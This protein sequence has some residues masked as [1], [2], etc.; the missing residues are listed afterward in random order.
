M[1][2]DGRPLT[3]GAGRADA[4]TGAGLVLDGLATL[5]PNALVDQAA[6]AAALRV[7]P[8][9]VRRMVARGELPE[10]VKLG[11]RRLWLAGRVVEHLAGR[12]ERAEHEAERRLE[13]IRRLSP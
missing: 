1:T 11:S 5:A 3:T 10:A 7:N 12:A 13:R 4:V 8:R 6:L 2:D 9:T